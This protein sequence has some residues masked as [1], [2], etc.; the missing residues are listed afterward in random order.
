MPSSAWLV[1]S[2]RMPDQSFTVDGTPTSV[3]AVNAYLRHSTSS[4]SLISLFE[5]AIDAAGGPTSTVEIL[6]NRRARIT[7]SASADIAWTTATTLRDVLGFTQGNLT[8][9]ASYTADSVSPLLWSP[10]YLATPKTIFGV[11]GYSV[12]HQSIYKSDDGTEVYASH[13]GEETW[14]DLEWQHIVPERLRVD[15]SSD[16]GGTFHEF[17]EQ[18]AKLRRRF[19]YYESVSEDDASTSAVTWTTRRGPY[20]MRPEADGDWYRRNVQNAEVSSPLSLPM[21]M[22]AEI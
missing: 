15:D 17:W 21:H 14:Q 10:G 11:D 18:C 1:G 6:R 5:D 16:G 4:I 20:V 8:G 19:S 9:A 22:L 2:Y 7:L 3:T 12:D 13:Y